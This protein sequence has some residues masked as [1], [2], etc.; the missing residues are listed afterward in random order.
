[1]IQTQKVISLRVSGKLSPLSSS[2]LSSSP[3]SSSSSSSS[4]SS[5]DVK[6]TIKLD[7]SQI[8][9]FL[10]KIKPASTLPVIHDQPQSHDSTPVSSEKLSMTQ[11]SYTSP[12]TCDDP[13]LP[14]TNQINPLI[15]LP[16]PSNPPSDQLPSIV[17]KENNSAV[18]ASGFGPNLVTS[19]NDSSK[20]L[21]L[22]QHLAI[23]QTPSGREGFKS[24]MSESCSSH[25]EKQASPSFVSLMCGKN[26]TGSV[27]SSDTN[28]EK[29]LLVEEPFQIT[30]DV[31]GATTSAAV[32]STSE[33]SNL[34]PEVSSPAELTDS[35]WSSKI[36][37]STDLSGLSQLS[38]PSDMMEDYQ[39][40]IRQARTL[41]KRGKADLLQEDRNRA[42][43]SGDSKLQISKASVYGQ[44]LFHKDEDEEEDEPLIQGKG[45]SVS[46]ATDQD[47][48]EITETNSVRNQ[49]FSLDQ[50]GISDEPNLSLVSA[51]GDETPTVKRGNQAEKVPMLVDSGLSS[52]DHATRIADNVVEN[53]ELLTSHQKLDIDSQHRMRPEQIISNSVAEWKLKYRMS[54]QTKK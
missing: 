39:Y 15:I 14:Q 17:K 54:T 2:S 30:L 52:T 6:D 22:T 37:S 44:T 38:L 9:A 13:V 48:T 51:G 32:A 45:L 16:D 23:N 26:A 25:S 19:L 7:Q 27:S 29:M 46:K 35:H 36:A 40:L 31:D 50:L 34:T 21:S 42:Y 43:A 47:V 41:V 1:M 24:S 53:K 8:S 33:I 18:H 3:S 4:A 20:Y 12:E 11:Y 49:I 10:P 28:P 5:S